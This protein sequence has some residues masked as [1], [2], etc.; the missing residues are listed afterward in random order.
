[1]NLKFESLNFIFELPSNVK[2]FIK[3]ADL[4]EIGIGCSESQVIKIETNNETFFI[5]IAPIGTLTKE[6]TSLKWLN[7]KTKVPKIIMYEKT[8]DAEFL[9][10]EAIKGEMICSDYYLNHPEDGIPII[11]EAFKE[12]YK[13][14]ISSC[15]INVSLDYKLKLA[16]DNIDNNLILEENI[17]PDVLKEFGN[18]NNIYEF[19]EKNKFEEE[20]VF[21]HGDTSLPNIFAYNNKFSGFID[22]GECG[23]ADKWFDIAIV[24][25]SIIRN[26]DEKYLKD[27][28][29]QLNIMPDQEKIDYYI[30]LME[31]YL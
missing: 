23:I 21:S 17:L 5:K 14:D 6:Y 3:N 19:L 27:F 9:I 13:I 10:T 12:I 31:L 7:G 2:D 28:Y 24:S 30:L 18:I 26:Y 1:M 8:D 15:P 25:R 4:S 11:V 20:L 29:D 16:K 22:V